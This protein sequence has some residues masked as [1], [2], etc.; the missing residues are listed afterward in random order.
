MSDKWVKWAVG[1]AM[2][3]LLGIGVWVGTLNK[4]VSANERKI[5]TV[6]ETVRDIDK[7]TVAILCSVAPD[8]CPVR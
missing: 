8:K 5:D 3:L 2:P 4:T 6:A 1:T 7:R